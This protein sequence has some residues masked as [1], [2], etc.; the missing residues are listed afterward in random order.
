[1][2][3]A[4]PR[5]TIETELAKIDAEQ[6]IDQR[7]L[8]EI[9]DRIRAREIKRSVYADILGLPCS[10]NSANGQSGARQERKRLRSAKKTHKRGAPSQVV[11][12]L[13]RARPNQLKMVDIINQAE[14]LIETESTK[15]RPLLRST[16]RNLRTKN[17]L[18][19]NED[20]T[21][22]PG[23]KATAD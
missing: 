15:K 21:Y 9:Q 3:D 22:G 5:Q 23:A 7:N 6:E 19:L 2:N 20:E 10:S 17:K 12:E 18:V 13:V 8:G 11:L 1:M 14:S 16:I 4:I